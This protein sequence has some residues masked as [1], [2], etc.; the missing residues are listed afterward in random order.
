V[1]VDLRRTGE[2]IGAAAGELTRIWRSARLEA[3]PE[4]FPGTLDGVVE[5]FVTAVGDALVLGQE[6]EEIWGRLV[7]TVRA[8]RAAPGGLRETWRAE[9]G[10]LAA[11]LAATC[12]ALEAQA[13][14]VDRVARAVEGA[15]RGTEALLA[16]EGPD[17][18]LVVWTLGGFRPR[19][20]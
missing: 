18:V 11:V 17:G 9:W 5:P 19:E 7:G 8:D 16:G 10:L 20:S 12:D 4:L 14:A 3:L 1:T 13:D 15:R 6:P 2:A